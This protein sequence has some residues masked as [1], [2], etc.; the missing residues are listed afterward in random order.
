MLY[1]VDDRQPNHMTGNPNETEVPLLATNPTERTSLDFGLS[2]GLEQGA[3]SR[4][5]GKLVYF[6]CI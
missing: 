5:T 2:E 1:I 6:K 3:R 4:N